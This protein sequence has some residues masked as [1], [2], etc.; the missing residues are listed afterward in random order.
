MTKLTRRG[1]MIFGTAALGA[2]AAPKTAAAQLNPELP[3]IFNPNN[4]SALLNFANAMGPAFANAASLINKEAV[5][6]AR[7]YGSSVSCIPDS[8]AARKISRTASK[9]VEV[10]RHQS[11]RTAYDRAIAVMRTRADKLQFVEPY[12]DDIANPR[13]FM[14]SC[15]QAYRR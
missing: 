3:G 5:E 9:F 7:N 12:L 1:F 8:E 11:N 13:P 4:Q 15:T 2:A 10:A 14:R 6:V